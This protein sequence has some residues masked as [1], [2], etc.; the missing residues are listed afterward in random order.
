MSAPPPLPTRNTLALVSLNAA[1][2]GFFLLPFVGSLVAII[3]GHL[4]RSHLR[5]RSYR[6]RYDDMA[7]PAVAVGWIGLAAWVLGT[8]AMVYWFIPWL[9]ELLRVLGNAILLK[10]N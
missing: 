5:R 1:L 9:K 4:A 3:T 8:L 10:S 7:L 6:L 2:L